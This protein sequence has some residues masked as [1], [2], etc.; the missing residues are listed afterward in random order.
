MNTDKREKRAANP[1]SRSFGIGTKSGRG[2]RRLPAGRIRRRPRI[3]AGAPGPPAPAAGGGGREGG[4]Q[5]DPGGVPRLSGIG[6]GEWRQRPRVA[7]EPVREKK[8]GH[9]SRAS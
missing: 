3:P 7:G 2:R 8:T 6:G 1:G 5:K 9:G 4:G